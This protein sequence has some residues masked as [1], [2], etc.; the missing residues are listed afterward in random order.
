VNFY[1]QK[2]QRCVEAVDSNLCVGLDPDPERM[3]AE[4]SGISDPS[5]RLVA[6]CKTIIDQTRPFAAAYKPNLAFFEALGPAAFY[7]F[8]EVVAYIGNDKIVIADAKRG[9]IG[10]TGLQYKK[11]FFDVLKVDALTVNP[12]MGIETLHPYLDA[13]SKAIY[14]LVLTSNPGAADFMLNGASG[15]TLPALELA[16]ALH[17]LQH[18]SSTHIGMVLRPDLLKTILSKHATGSV[19]VPGFGTQGGDVNAIK[20]S[21]H[22]NSALPLFNVSRDIIFAVEHDYSWQTSVKRAA[23]RW[24]SALSLVYHAE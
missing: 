23:E 18:S 15:E 11:A 13:P 19:L 6:F 5:D 10:N 14:V 2:L 9:D 1:T 24:S 7:A 17:E 16:K 4:L 3:P 12:W 20:A 21:F 22:T 8:S